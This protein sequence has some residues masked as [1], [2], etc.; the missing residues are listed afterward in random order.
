[1]TRDE[2]ELRAYL[3]DRFDRSRLERW[4][5]QLEE[6]ARAVGDEERLYR[7]SEAYLYNLTVFAMSGT[8]EPYRDAIRRVVEPEARLLD[9]GCGIGSDGLAL[10]DAGYAVE[11]A[12]FDNPSTRYLRWRLERR[13]RSAAVHDLDA[14]PLPEGFDL[15]YAFDVLEHVE[16][17]LALLAAMERSAALVCVNLLVD[18]GSDDS[19]LHRALPVRRIA[20]R[21]R[22]RGLVLDERLWDGRVRLLIYRGARRRAAPR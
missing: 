3:G 15:A 2:E 8:K 13:G 19:V 6:E 18:A 10:L 4:Q 9:V 21:A 22:R 14:G 17:P 5:E 7:T 20:W 1:M 12:D 16:D 11:F